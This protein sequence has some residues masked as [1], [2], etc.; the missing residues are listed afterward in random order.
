MSFSPRQPAEV[1]TAGEGVEKD[2]DEENAWSVRAVNSMNEGV[3]SKQQR[4]PESRLIK[5]LS[6]RSRGQAQ[7]EDEEHLDN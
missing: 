3:D 6:R 1:V 5:S 2:A 7:E 4:Q